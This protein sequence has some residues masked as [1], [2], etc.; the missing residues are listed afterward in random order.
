M[1]K[2]TA[3]KFFDLFMSALGGENEQI[4]ANEY[5]NSGALWTTYITFKVQEFLEKQLNL[6]TNKEYFR[7]DMIGWSG[8]D[9]WSEKDITTNKDQIGY[10]SHK[11][12][13]RSELK[14]DEYDWNLEVAVEFEN[15]PEK[16]SDEVIKLCHIKCGIKVVIA[17]NYINERNLD[18]E[19]LE[20]VAEHMRNLSYGTPIANEEF[21][22][23]LGNCRRK[24]GSYTDMKSIEYIAY[25]FD[26]EHFNELS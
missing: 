4:T 10:L 12:S 24:E 16:W 1:E 8:N 18:M 13:S 2:V 25:T 19:K 7:I 3:K 21:M 9:K 6:K 26:G 15:E 14:L 11:K 23:I 20:F 22:V 5:K 17:Y